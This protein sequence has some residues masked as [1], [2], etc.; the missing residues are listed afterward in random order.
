MGKN[1]STIEVRE[2]VVV[3]FANNTQNQFYF[4]I[5]DLHLV[6]GIGWQESKDGY[7]R[8]KINGKTVLAHTV[9]A[10]KAPKGRVES[11]R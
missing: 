6:E 8:A 4:D 9:I 1:P 3:V 7:L 2:D 10:G 11:N 5:E